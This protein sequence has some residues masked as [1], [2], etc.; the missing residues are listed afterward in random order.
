MTF[1]A[2]AASA[3]SFFGLLVYLGDARLVLV[4]LR[5]DARGALGLLRE[6]AAHALRALAAVLNAVAQHGGLGLRLGDPGLRLGEARPLLLGLHVLLAHA[7]RERL[8]AGIQRLQLAPGGVQAALGRLVVVRYGLGLLAQAVERVHPRADLLDPQLVA[9]GEVALGH[10]RLLLERADL[11]LQLVYLVVHAQEVLVRPREA[12]L[13]LLL[14]VAEAGDARGLLQHL[15]ALG[16]LAVDYLRYAALADYGVAVPA[17]AGVHEQLVHV[18]QAHL[19]AVYIVLALARAVIAAGYGYLLRVDVE[20]AA[21]VV[22]N[23]RHLRKTHG[24]ALGRAAEDDVL[25]LAAAQ[26]L[27]ALLAHDPEDGVGN[28]R[29]A[30]AVRPHDGRYLLLERQPGLVRE[31]FEAL[32]L[33]CL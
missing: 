23:E 1:R 21:G 10:L 30:G 22:Q 5:G 4:Y 7:L 11:E 31:G 6:L 18:A 32:Y 28:I 24:P 2:E 25:H 15:A 29:F 13:R 9:Q 19:V 26:G 3:S 33:Q 27:A 14:A 16:A 17:Q 20:D 8:A 12:A